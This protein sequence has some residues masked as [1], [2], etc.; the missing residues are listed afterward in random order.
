MNRISI[1]VNH[2]VE[3]HDPRPIFYIN[4]QSSNGCKLRYAHAFW[5]EHEA[6]E[7]ADQ[8]RERVVHGGKL[9]PKFWQEAAL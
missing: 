8:I 9:D 4:V 7:V 1:Y 3:Q 6:E 5:R 2:E